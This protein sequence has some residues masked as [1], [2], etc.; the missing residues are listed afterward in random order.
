[1]ENIK[2][3][4]PA[5]TTELTVNG[6]HQWDYGRKLEIHAENLPA[7]VEVHFASI[8]MEEAVV[9][10]C[11]VINGV[12]IATIPDRCLE[13]TAP[14]H[15]WLYVIED[16]SGATVRT[17]TMPVVAR[18]KP[19]PGAS[20]PDEISDRYTEALAAMD[21][22]FDKLVDG[23]VK[24]E[25]AR[26]ADH[27]TT[28]D[29]AQ[30]AVMAETADRASHA[31]TATTAERALDADTAGVAAD[32]G[33]VYLHQ[34]RAAVPVYA[35][36]T[37]GA[38]VST[39]YLTIEFSDT[40][41]ARQDHAI[42]NLLLAGGVTSYPRGVMVLGA[43]QL[44]ITGLTYEGMAEAG[45]KRKLTLDVCGSSYPFYFVPGEVEITAYISKIR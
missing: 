26:T 14:V 37:G 31:A 15:A 11:E 9:R 13:Q 1:M 40:R 43:T 30:G 17:V 10:A 8:G 44:F 6:L 32:V 39:L 21:A 2:A 23:T 42:S 7:I 19:Q 16:T 36:A 41:A 18:T 22:L 34:Y 33:A 5:G 28:A 45:S 38:Q 24:L 25:H 27:A 4:F 3:T 35:T 29:N 20:V 12:A